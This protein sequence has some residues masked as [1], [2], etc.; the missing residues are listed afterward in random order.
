MNKTYSQE[1]RALKEELRNAGTER[2]NLTKK[3]Q[4]LEAQLKLHTNYQDSIV[5]QIVEIRNRLKE[6]THER[7]KLRTSQEM[8]MSN[9]KETKVEFC[10]FDQSH[11]HLMECIAITENLNKDLKK[12]LV[13]CRSELTMSKSSTPVPLQENNSDSER[14]ICQKRIIELEK[15]FLQSRKENEKT[16]NNLVESNNRLCS[17]INKCAEL[18]E[19]EKT[20]SLKTENYEKEFEILQNKLDEQVIELERLRLENTRAQVIKEVE[21][22]QTQTE[23]EIDE[24]AFPRTDTSTS[25]QFENKYISENEKLDVFPLL[26]NK[27]D[28]DVLN[29][30]PNE[31]NEVSK[32]KRHVAFV[33]NTDNCDQPFKKPCSERNFVNQ[34]HVEHDNDL[35]LP[36]SMDSSQNSVICC[37]DNIG[38][39][40]NSKYENSFTGDIVVNETDAKELMNVEKNLKNL[41]VF[42][43]E[44]VMNAASKEEGI[45]KQ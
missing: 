17:F 2:L 19:I 5:K 42:D 11:K 1:V 37:D 41:Q 43:Y 22:A 32:R 4:A 29:I 33:E 45:Q 7:E 8:V 6:L 21:E 31:A 18:R 24:K 25:K 40:K 13:S 23:L 30:Q 20:L 39:S 38:I 44:N 34:M 12:E 27:I 14:V 10:K 28:I 3:I 9:I 26:K 15:L 36:S 35:S 16:L